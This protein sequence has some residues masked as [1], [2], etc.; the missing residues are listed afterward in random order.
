LS[1]NNFESKLAPELIQSI[2]SNQAWH[3]GIIPFG[4]NNNKRTFFFSEDN[5]VERLV[6][7]L[8]LVFNSKVELIPKKVELIKELLIRYYRRTELEN[9]ENLV[10]DLENF[11][12]FLDRLIFEAKSLGSSDIHFEIYKKNARVRIRID[13]VLIERFVIDIKKFAPLVNKIKIKA[14]L[15]ISEK[16]L[17]QDGRISIESESGDFDL[18]VS[19]LPTLFGEK[20]VLRILSQNA[21]NLSLEKIGLNTDHMKMVLEAIQKPNGIILVSGPTGS[22]KTTTL[23]SA[24]KY[25]NKETRNILTIEDP[26]E[27]TLDG[28]N[29]VQLKES[30][31]LDFFSTLKSFLRQDPDIIMI[32]EIRDVDTAQMAIRAALTGHLVFSTIHTN[33][34]S[35]T[36]NRLID[37]GIPK[38]L[39]NSTLNISIAQRLVRLL[40]PKCKLKV[41]KEIFHKSPVQ[42]IKNR[43]NVFSPQGCPE[44]HYTGY[45]GRKAIYEVLEVK[46][47]LQEDN[48]VGE[49]YSKGLRKEAIK[50][51]E[52]GETSVSEIMT[53]LV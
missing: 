37:M 41:Q 48:F 53:Y 16:R 21:D 24:L 39:I 7:E 47:R 19:I 45:K 26:I 12:N 4:K 14:K 20:V 42:Q 1:S 5:D 23:Y 33:S 49:I 51:V 52:D 28:I 29:Q 25:L 27:Y 35:E 13:G 31:G 2:N 44:C 40:C 22:G 30:I 36:V 6:E 34:A 17:P 11:E 50:L 38:F 18:R 43:E 15:D 3:Y 46:E 8:E 32:G 10:V 9:R